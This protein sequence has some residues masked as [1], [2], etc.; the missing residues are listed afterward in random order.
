MVSCDDF[1]LMLYSIYI[2]LDAN[3]FVTFMYKLINA[4]ILKVR[5]NGLV[6]VLLSKPA[7]SSEPCMSRRRP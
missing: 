4:K 3:V 1:L 6:A 5:I 2:F 7:T